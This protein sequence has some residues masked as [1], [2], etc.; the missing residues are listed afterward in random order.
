MPLKIAAKIGDPD[1]A[2]Y[3][4]KIRPQIDGSFIEYLGEISD[5]EK[6]E[7]LGNA[8][9]LVFP[10]AWPEPFGLVMIEA[11]ATGTPVLAR[12]FGAVR[13]VVTD[14]RTG[15]IRN[16]ISDLVRCVSELPNLDRRACRTEVERRF[17]VERMVRD[18]VEVFSGMKKALHLEAVHLE[19]NRRDQG[20]NAFV[21]VIEGVVLHEVE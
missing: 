9:A 4:E 8:Q 14:G 6:S 15:Y 2:Y 21:A 10:I 5:H 13:E 3:E 12:P 7:F 20:S 16:E 17:S 18:Y 1:R 19:K 11:L